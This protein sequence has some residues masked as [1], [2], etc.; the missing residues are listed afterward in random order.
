MSTLS[1]LR[2]FV[3]PPPATA[4]PSPAAAQVQ[5]HPCPTR[6]DCPHCSHATKPDFDWSF[7]DGVYC[8]SMRHRDDRAAL[9][10]GELHRV[11]L[12][13]RTLF[14]R[15]EKA[16]SAKRGCWEAHRAVAAD[17]RARGL[18]RV[19]VLEDDFAFSRSV[20]PATI[21]RIG[22]ALRRLP[23]DWQGFYLGHWALWA[24]P[25]ARRVL[26]CS[27]LCTHAYI[28]SERLLAWLAETPF[29]RRGAVARRR[30]GGRGIDASFAALPDMY[31]FFPLVVSQ[32]LVTGDHMLAPHLRFAHP[33][34]LLRDLFVRSRLREYA[35][36][37][38]MGANEKLVLAL[39]ALLLPGARAV[40]GT[41]RR[42][43]ASH[44]RGGARPAPAL[45]GVDAPRPGV[46]TRVGPA[47]EA[48]ATGEGS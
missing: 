10:A 37:Y 20:S 32:R 7:V 34:R 6:L 1:S 48:L 46:A 24:Y 18:R 5:L 22:A 11:G 27:S 3:R 31:A 29:D 39:T 28:A 21:A 8:I 19:L 42:V 43:R 15:T 44:L 47:A 14:V 12:C 33:K 41:A 26:R 25:V 30:I 17:A 23:A 38:A 16:G 45:H 9:A 13:A 35:M 36:A 40:A 2:P 4:P